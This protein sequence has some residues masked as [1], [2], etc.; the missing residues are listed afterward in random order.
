M[1]VTLCS[2]NL[3][4]PLCRLRT[5]SGWGQTP[6]IDSLSGTLLLCPQCLGTVRQVDVPVATSDTAQAEGTGSCQTTNQVQ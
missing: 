6:D 4:T 3:A 5:E 1:V 2:G